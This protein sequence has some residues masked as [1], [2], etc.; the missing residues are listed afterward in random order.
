MN[1][2]RMVMLGLKRVVPAFRDAP[3]GNIRLNVGCG[4]TVI[5]G[6]LGVDHPSNP[7]PGILH[8]DADSGNPL[9]FDNKEVSEIH[10][11]HFLEHCAHP[12]AVLQEFQRILRPGGVLNIVVPHYSSQLAI[13]DLDHKFQFC[14]DTWKTL[15]NTKYYNK[16]QIQWHFTIGFNMLV[17]VVERNLCVFTQL[18]KD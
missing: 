16:N 10:C 18:I 8:W 17:G 13:E 6:T 12:V 15:F 7:T 14:E 3:E 11:Y 5:G 4:A 2:H 9:P 1:F